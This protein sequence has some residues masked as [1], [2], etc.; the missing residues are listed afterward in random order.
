VQKEEVRQCHKI[1]HFECRVCI[2]SVCL[3]CI[4]CVPRCFTV[5][6][7]TWGAGCIIPGRLD[8]FARRDLDSDRLIPVYSPK[9]DRSQGYK[10]ARHRTIVLGIPGSSLASVFAVQSLPRYKL[11][12]DRET[13]HRRRA[14][15]PIPC[16]SSFI[17]ST[18]IYAKQLSDFGASHYYRLPGMASRRNPAARHATFHRHRYAG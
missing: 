4:R 9:A 14:S 10:H 11:P 8:S 5:S 15:N 16:S 2:L 3:R 1:S 13:R 18:T 6:L 17:P 12:S 7:C